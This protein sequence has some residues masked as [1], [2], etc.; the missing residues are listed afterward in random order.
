HPRAQ[1]LRTLGRYG[2]PGAEIGVVYALGGVLAAAEYVV[3]QRA[4]QRPVLGVQL[5]YTLLR[6][7][8]KELQY[9][10]ILHPAPPLCPQTYTIISHA[11]TTSERKNIRI[12]LHAAKNLPCA[13]SKR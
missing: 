7:R 1:A 9:G 10:L 3:G 8:E 13:S 4:A 12:C 11:R 5:A 6:A 2:P